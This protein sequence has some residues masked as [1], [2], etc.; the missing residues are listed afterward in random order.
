MKSAVPR[1]RPGEL[2]GGAWPGLTALPWNLRWGRWLSPGRTPGPALPLRRRAQQTGGLLATPHASCNPA[3]FQLQQ[4]A[5][6]AREARPD[7]PTPPLARL[8]GVK[9]EGTHVNLELWRQSWVFS[10]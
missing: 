9:E 2:D 7:P 10:A 1:L 4:E 5:V 6:N 8:K 3:T